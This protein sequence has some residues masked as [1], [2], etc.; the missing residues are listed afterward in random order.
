MIT[1]FLY[2]SDYIS[3]NSYGKTGLMRSWFSV[4]R[5]SFMCGKLGNKME[6]F[7]TPLI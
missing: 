2:A 5:R 7:G 3:N 1:I 4:M 6:E